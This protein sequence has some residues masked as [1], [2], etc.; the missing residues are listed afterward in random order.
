[1]HGL[2][3]LG[4]STSKQEKAAA[5]DTLDRSTRTAR[6]V[7]LP[8]VHDIVERQRGAPRAHPVP[9]DWDAPVEPAPAAD[10]PVSYPDPP[11]AVSL[12][13]VFERA[14]D[15]MATDP[16]VRAV[17]EDLLRT[18]GFSSAGPAGERL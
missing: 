11:A 18:L 8:K 7:T 6:G 17:M 9:D 5:V 10:E 14:R 15:R 2:L 12:A 3:D 1:M 13:T 4:R 16:A